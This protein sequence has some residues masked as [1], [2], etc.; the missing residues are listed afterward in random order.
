MSTPT[1]PGTWRRLMRLLLGVGLPV[2]LLALIAAAG[3]FRRSPDDAGPE[4][5]AG[6]PVE[7]AQWTIE[8]ISAEYVNRALDDYEID[9]TVR[10]TM[11]LTWHGQE[12]TYGLREGLLTVRGLDEA[13]A[14]SP[15]TNGHDRSGDIDPDI[16]QT[17][18]Y[19]IPY[20]DTDRDVAAVSTPAQVQVVL[21][22]EERHDSYLSGESWGLGPTVGHVVLP[23]P[24]R[25]EPS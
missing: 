17:I 23:C 5:P 2:L 22:D 20:P 3:G 15:R 14:G 13:A 25:R 24:D 10:I 4:L 8:V 12:S 6:Q 9:D 19:E 7:L 21:R 16:P 1:S 18:A 11:R